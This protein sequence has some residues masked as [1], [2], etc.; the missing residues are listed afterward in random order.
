MMPQARLSPEHPRLRPSILHLLLFT[1]VQTI[2]VA[3]CH[4][5]RLAPHT[6]PLMWL[7]SGLLLAVLVRFPI[8]WWPW[9]LGLTVVV[10][11]AVGSVLYPD[12]SLRVAC[13]AIGHAASLGATAWFVRQP[14]LAPVG[15]LE[16]HQLIRMLVGLLLSS[17]AVAL[18]G[19]SPWFAPTQLPT[20]GPVVLL[21]GLLAELLGMVAFT[22]C[23]LAAWDRASHERERR[24]E[25]MV[26]LIIMTSAVA[27][28]AFKP[29]GLSW[30]LFGRPSVV[31]PAFLWGGLRLSLS[32]VSLAQLLV[33]TIVVAGT[34]SGG[35]PFPAA[36][37]GPE[38]VSAAAQALFFTV[39]TSAITL[40][41]VKRDFSK[42]HERLNDALERLEN[43]ILGAGAGTWD[44]NVKTHETIYSAAWKRQLDYN[45]DALPNT[46]DT[47]LD[48]LHPDDKESVLAFHDAFLR[49]R[50]NQPY[51]QEFRLRA[52]DGSYRWISSRAQLTS[53]DGGAREWLSGIH[54]D[55]TDRKVLESNIR[56]RLRYEEI[57]S[58]FGRQFL[59]ANSQE[60][61]PTLQRAVD[62]VGGYLRA[63]RLGLF[64]FNADFSSPVF[65][66]A[67]RT[68]CA[69]AAA[70][71][72][73][74]LLNGSPAGQ[75]HAC[76]WLMQR[77]RS[78]ET[79]IFVRL[80]DLPPEAHRERAAFASRAVKSMAHIPLS[81]GGRVLGALY[82]EAI[83]EER[84]WDFDTIDRFSLFSQLL[85]VAIE[86]HRFEQELSLRAERER[87]ISTISS[88]FVNCPIE[89]VEE[90]V[91][92][93]LETMGKLAGVDRCF[94]FELT[95]DYQFA[96]N[97]CEWC[98][99]GVPAMKPT[100][101]D[102][103][104]ASFEGLLQRALTGESIYL[105]NV[106][107]A[108]DLH[109][110][111][112]RDLLGRSM[113]S[114]VLVPL[115]LAGKHVGAIGQGTVSDG[116][117]WSQEWMPLLKL[118]GEMLVGALERRRAALALEE[119]RAQL[120][121]AS[122]LAV[123]GEMIAGIAHE[124]RQPLHAMRS[125]AAACVHAVADTSDPALSDVR[126]WNE[127]IL[128]LVDRS[129][130][131]IRR[132]RD[133]CRPH[134]SEFTSLCV[135]DLV[136]EAIQML[137]GDLRAGHVQIDLDIPP[138]PP[139]WCGDRIQL[140]QVLVN[141]FKNAC[142]AM[143][144]TP[145]HQ[146]RIEVQLD[147]SRA[148][149]GLSTLKIRD[150]GEG[151]APNADTQA[152][153]PFWSSKPHGTGLGL[154]VCRTIINDHGG[155]IWLEPAAQGT[156]VFIELPLEEAKVS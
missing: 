85:S 24:R 152:F 36:T 10:E 3:A 1:L 64:E 147:T 149:Q 50:P 57:L 106:G 35:G 84:S 133:F 144:D 62:E 155:R 41:I 121:A 76:P 26:F 130:E 89:D 32:T 132:Y 114:A 79:V 122:R 33:T 72:P 71:S 129:N 30:S 39:S 31:L 65:H 18:A 112:I 54:V 75:P 74:P 60:L 142:D 87:A 90:E 55:I 4:A 16:L 96:S 22:P 139:R 56:D 13:G 59:E 116:H 95:A 83:R 126:R 6:V 5:A 88:R 80:D 43:T 53:R 113:K 117:A 154:A 23:L 49:D 73:H 17:T 150:Y 94:Y 143:A 118:V 93:A 127:R 109:D 140:E 61:R 58:G 92:F 153:E 47:F 45:D 102:I 128:L 156:Q 111:G 48:L 70:V 14:H 148:E 63:D 25:A 51:L 19:L 145:L 77:T 115:F 21:Q 44:F 151:L 66:H 134:K 40:V 108:N 125:F 52:S 136:S 68:D 11:V 2:V 110:D 101:Q 123:M 135:S 103:P 7:A 34:C 99:P 9:W 20:L 86:R 8:A 105:Q 37:V 146:R 131:I 119:N 15:T 120:T 42:Q 67:Y 28:L 124:I 69:A 104:R 100:Q 91:Q 29:I 46:F 38:Q 27:L 81:S 97:R 137:L 82:V 98:A 141:V 107:D 78:G 138:H 12:A